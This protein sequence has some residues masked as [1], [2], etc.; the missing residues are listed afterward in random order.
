MS[1]AM[2]YQ[3]AKFAD[4][5]SMIFYDGKSYDFWARQISVTDW[6]PSTSTSR[7]SSA[8][9]CRRSEFKS[10]RDISRNSIIKINP[11][12]NCDDYVKKSK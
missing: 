1:A 8:R 2:I 5:S 10:E 11:T 7:W 4:S 3:C 12:V 9:L 6:S